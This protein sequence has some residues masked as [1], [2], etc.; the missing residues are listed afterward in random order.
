KTIK[1]KG[2]L[3]AHKWRSRFGRPSKIPAF[4][5]DPTGSYCAIPVDWL[6]RKLAE[7]APPPSTQDLWKIFMVNAVPFI[8]FGFLDNFTMIIAG[9][10]IEHCFGMFMCISTMAAAGLGNTISDVLGIG[11]AYYVERG[12]EMLGLK[13]PDLTPI[14]MDMKSSRRAGN[15][16]R[17]FGITAGC[18]IGMFPLLFIDSTKKKDDEKKD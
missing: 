4:D 14:Q 16:G 15:M 18:L 7:K 5:P 13:A 8:G 2:E 3:A 11:S 10:Y 12:C 9:D 17:I 6:K 1:K